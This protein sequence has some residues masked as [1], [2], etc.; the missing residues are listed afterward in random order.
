MTIPI[1]SCY[2]A[3]VQEPVQVLCYLEAMSFSVVVGRHSQV[4]K[5]EGIMYKKKLNFHS[6]DRIELPHCTIADESA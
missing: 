3:V 4:S 2:C 5:E 6:Y 1:L